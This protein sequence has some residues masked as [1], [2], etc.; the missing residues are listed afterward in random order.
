M[1]GDRAG[2]GGVGRAVLARGEDG[3]AGA[4]RG[5]GRAGVRRRVVQGVQRRSVGDQTPY[6]FGGDGFGGAD[7]D[8]QRAGGGARRGQWGGRPAAE[9]PAEGEGESGGAGQYD[10]G[11]DVQGGGEQCVEVG[12]RLR[13]GDDGESGG[14]RFAQGG[15]QV[16]VLTPYGLESQE[17]DGDAE[18]LG[19]RARWRGGL[20]APGVAGV[21]GDAVGVEDTVADGAALGGQGGGEEHAPAGGRQCGDLGGEVS[22]QQGVDLL[23]DDGVGS[24]PGQDGGDPGGGVRGGELA[25]VEVEDG[26]GAGGRGGVR[27][28]IEQHSC[29]CCAREQCGGGLGRTRQIVGDCEYPL[30]G[31][32]RHEPSS[33]WN[34]CWWRR[35]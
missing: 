27:A 16:V 15:A 28:R 21:Q 26:G 7:D 34:F 8:E 9:C 4:E 1:P 33:D 18:C 29:A 6:L 5:Q 31:S 23:A 24:E 30:A 19:D 35:K 12:V 32:E 11:V 14:E 3:D 10:A 22:A 17:R 20:G 2:G 25:R 13:V